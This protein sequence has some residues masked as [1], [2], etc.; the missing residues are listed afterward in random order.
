[1]RAP[2]LDA[3]R[4]G[5][6]PSTAP[7]CCVVRQLQPRH[8]HP[9]DVQARY[10]T[11]IPPHR[12]D[13]WAMNEAGT[14]GATIPSWSPAQPTPERLCWP[15]AARVRAPVPSCCTPRRSSQTLTS[16]SKLPSGRLKIH[17][18]PACAHV[19]SDQGGLDD[20][21]APTRQEYDS[22]ARV[23]RGRR[24]LRPRPDRQPIYRS[25]VQLENLSRLGQPAGEGSHPRLRLRQ[26]RVPRTLPATA[27]GMGALGQRR[28]R[29]PPCVR[30]AAHRA[31]SRF[32][33]D[34]ARPR[35][36]AGRTVRP[37]HRCSSLAEHLTDPAATLARLAALLAPGG[38]LYLTVPNVI[39]NTIDA[40]LADHLSHFS[41]PSLTVLLHRCGLRPVVGLRASPARPDHADGRARAR[42]RRAPRSIVWAATWRSPTPI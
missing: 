22:A 31:R 40:F 14:S 34:G 9:L 7:C 29:A 5:P 35:R 4:T 33:R 41:T 37:D 1:M 12:H 39:V 3:A 19:M 24:S 16:E 30:R 6:T 18:C 25:Q 15:P 28:L 10:L 42:L 26:G 20:S 21:S 32:A 2:A 13:W 17:L 8:R 11:S 36:A 27:S 38:L 23:H